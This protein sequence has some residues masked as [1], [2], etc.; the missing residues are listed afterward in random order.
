MIKYMITDEND[1]RSRKNES[2]LIMN[3]IELV[4]IIRL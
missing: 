4:N 2:K 3:F 1:L